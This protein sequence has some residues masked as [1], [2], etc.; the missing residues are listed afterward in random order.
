ME[1][2][3][4][5]NTIYLPLRPYVNLNIFIFYVNKDILDTITEGIPVTLL[6]FLINIDSDTF[7]LTVTKISFSQR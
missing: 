5:L 2:G 3:N 1:D 6:Y 7:I 4:C